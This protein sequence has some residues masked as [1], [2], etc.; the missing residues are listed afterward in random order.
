[1]RE[2]IQQEME[3]EMENEQEFQSYLNQNSCVA[4][5][6]DLAKQ[7]HLG[8]PEPPEGMRY[9]MSKNPPTLVKKAGKESKRA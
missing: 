1:M 5:V 9:D 2:R 4:V 3:G 8:L 6:N 7:R